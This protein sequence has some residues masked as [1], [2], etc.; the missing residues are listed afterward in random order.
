MVESRLYGVLSAGSP[1][2]HKIASMLRSYSSNVNLIGNYYSAG[3]N[4][5]QGSAMNWL[6]AAGGRFY[7]F[8]DLA[9][10]HAKRDLDLNN[11]MV[12]VT[13]R[14]KLSKTE[15]LKEFFDVQNNW[16][17][18][19]TRFA[20]NN[21]LK[22]HA[23]I[24]TGHTFNQMAEYAVQTVSMYATLNN[25]KVKDKNGKY[26]NKKGEV[27]K[28]RDEAMSLDEAFEVGFVAKD[29][30]TTI[31]KDDHRK[32]S[33]KVQKTYTY[34]VLHLNPKVA[35]TDRADGVVDVDSIVKVSE[36]LRKVSRDLY[37]NYSAKNKAALERYAVGSLV[38][39]MRKWF[40]PGIKKRFR[41]GATLFRRDGEKLMD[42]A[43]IRNDE[44]NE[45][46]M[47]Y[48]KNADQHSEGMYISSLRYIMSTIADMKG[49]QA[50]L[51]GYI[52]IANPVA[53]M[54]SGRDNWAKLSESERQNVHRTV[55]EMAIAALSYISFLM[56]SAAMDDDDDEMIAMAAFFSRRLQGE[57]L[58]YL[59]PMELNRTL[60]TP[61]VSLSILQTSTKALTQL[62]SPFEEDRQ[63][64]NKLQ[65]SLFKLIPGQAAF[66]QTIDLLNFYAN[67]R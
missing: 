15:L 38:T 14:S 25:I 13:R 50:G 53:G 49:M 47:Y 55:A 56:L 31:S 6:E 1:E 7:G 32:L 30:K 35:S 5:T 33:P 17:P 65:K 42:L 52:N 24:G 41:G 43:V 60:R 64:N 16:M 45:L 48:D 2:A 23:N 11:I 10:A 57:L 12:D 46:N 26:L 18:L 39:H 19:D 37:G 54:K 28:T 9:Q 34:G 27:V 58:T 61:A 59:N 40:V 4:L 21:A 29:G 62:F 22:R 51:L 67:P 66:K 36:I 63:G 3:A 8:K 20:E 44:L